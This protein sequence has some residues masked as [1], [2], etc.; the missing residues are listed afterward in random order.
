MI[1]LTYADKGTSCYGNE[2]TELESIT[3]STESTMT[4]S[5]L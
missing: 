2:F 4:L 5:F 1:R 3:L